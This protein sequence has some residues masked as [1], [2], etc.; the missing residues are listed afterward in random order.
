M[1]RL[2]AIGDIHGCSKTFNSLLYKKLKIKKD[3]E[4]FCLGDFID[5][6]PNSKG[7]IDMIIDLRK[8][9]YKIHTLRGNHEQMMLDSGRGESE[10]DNWIRNGG[11]KTLE[12]FRVNKFS[13]LDR[14]YLHFFS[15][16]RLYLK[17]AKFIFVHAGLDFSSD[18]IFKNTEA[19]LWSRK[20]KVSEEKLKGRKIIHGHT[21]KA[22]ATIR[23]QLGKNVINIDGGCVFNGKRLYGNLVAIDLTNN[24]IISTPNID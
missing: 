13:E 11:G 12:S 16:T 21:I 4:I 22:L 20:F 8:Q 23:K 6:G 3:D 10:F 19:M 15:D 2:I 24:K 18:D 14:K 17:K 9:G 7:V 5:R 1:K